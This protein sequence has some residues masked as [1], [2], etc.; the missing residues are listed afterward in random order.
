VVKGQDIAALDVSDL[1]KILQEENANLEQKQI[2]LEKLLD[3]NI[4]K[5]SADKT[6]KLAKDMKEQMQKAYDNTKQLYEG[7]T[8]TED[9]LSNANRE[10]V[11]ANSDYNIALESKAKMLR[12]NERDIKNFQSDIDTQKRKIQDINHQISTN[13]LIKAPG[14]GTI[15]ELNFIKGSM[16]NSSK[17]I[18]KMAY[19]ES[20]FE[21]RLM[22]DS[23]NIGYLKA[24]DDINVTLVSLSNKVI[25]GKLVQISDN[26]QW[27]DKKDLLINLNDPDLKG[28]EAAEIDVVKKTKSYNILV[29]NDAINSDDNG[30]FIY[31]IKEAKGP[32]GKEQRLQKVSVQVEDSDLSKTAITA[33]LIKGEK[34]VISSNKPI[35]EDSNVIVTQ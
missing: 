18:Y 5:L 33:N 24:G 20:G 23:I 10:L 30:K 8:A 29:P 2:M 12:D 17:P 28:G 34:I 11:N 13:G 7:G 25:K 16:A 9:Q 26:I 35:S 1:Q 14:N 15:T 22:V 19:S 3:T 6:I 32:L 31:T 21:L 27:A 4:A